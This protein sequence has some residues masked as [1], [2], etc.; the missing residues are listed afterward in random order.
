M[1]PHESF[2]KQ[3]LAL[4]KRGKHGLSPRERAN[5]LCCS[6]MT[7]SFDAIMGLVSFT[8]NFSGRHGILA[9]GFRFN[10]MALYYVVFFFSQQRKLMGSSAQISSG[11][12]RCGSQEQVPE[13]GSGEFRCVL[14]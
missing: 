3:K 11:V 10:D 7:A 1:I 4:Q 5:S 13:E 6:G 12:C 9:L 8:M 2:G 14:V